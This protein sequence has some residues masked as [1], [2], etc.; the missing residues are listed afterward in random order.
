MNRRAIASAFAGR[1][2]CGLLLLATSCGRPEPDNANQATQ[3]SQNLTGHGVQVATDNIVTASNGAIAKEIGNETTRFNVL[4]RKTLQQKIDAG[5]VDSKNLKDKIN[6]T[7]LSEER[8]I[9]GMPTQLLDQEFIFGSVITKISDK[10]DSDLGNLKLMDLEPIH[11]RLAL[12]KK[13]ESFSLVFIGCVKNCSELS[14]QKPLVAV[15]IAGIDKDSKYIYLDVSA[16]GESLKLFSLLGGEEVLPWT[17]QKSKA[18]S[19]DFSK[20]T[21]VFDIEETLASKETTA[22]GAVLGSAA[23]AFTQKKDI[24]LTSRWYLKLSGGL[25]SSFTSRPQVSGVGFFETKRND[26]KLITRFSVTDNPTDQSPVH[27]YV[28]DVPVQWQGA[29]GKSFEQWNSVFKD[30]VNRNVLTYEFVN[31]DDPRRE[32]LVTGDVRYNILEWDLLNEASYGGLGPS[33]ASQFTGQTFAGHVLVQG[34]KIIELYSQW[35]QVNKSAQNLMASGKTQEAETTLLEGSRRLSKSLPK[36][37]LS[38]AAT[39]ADE[40]LNQPAADERL[41]DQLA[42]RMDFIPLPDGYSYEEYMNG[43]FLDLVTHELGH[44][45]GL[46]HNFRGNLYADDQKNTVSESVMEYLGR[47]FRHK[48]KIGIYDRMAIEY[49]YKGV[50]PN[51]TDMFCTDEDTRSS[52]NVFA[53]PECSRDDA[54]SDPFGNFEADAVRGVELLVRRGSPMAPEWRLEDMRDALKKDIEGMLQYGLTAE[55]SFSEWTNWQPKVGAKR[56]T[57]VKEVEEFVLQKIKTLVCNPVV[58]GAVKQKASSE[59]QEVT[60][61]NIDDLRAFLKLELNAFD[62][63]YDYLNC[64]K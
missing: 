3:N 55:V 19:V 18:T 50:K 13:A 48:D 54:T 21:L 59:A 37:E 8:L 52:R 34:P 38:F 43:Y 61:K 57:K 62:V 63:S 27:Y 58:I 9:V 6:E 42:S 15:P 51:R 11:V 60:R 5:T 56:P 14:V 64:K 22:L 26:K 1:S 20:S 17:V 32:K 49:A 31:A 16:L 53:N 33:L 29:F 41:R 28:L 45:L 36:S 40:T 25:N 23:T 4:N 35:Y 7:T 44:N 46:R 24:T 2:L 30:T 12:A 39:L 10:H 47:S